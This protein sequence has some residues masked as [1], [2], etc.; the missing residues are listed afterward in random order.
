MAKNPM[1]FSVRLQQE[2]AITYNL[3]VLKLFYSP[4]TL[5]NI[6]GHIYTLVKREKRGKRKLKTKNINNH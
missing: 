5:Q 4:V 1:T 2:R 6:E 3:N